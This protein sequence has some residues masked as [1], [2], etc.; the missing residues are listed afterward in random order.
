MQECTPHTQ[1]HTLRVP[2]SP[3]LPLVLFLTL[4]LSPSITILF[5]IPCTSLPSL[6]SVSVSVSN[7]LSTSSKT[8]RFSAFHSLL[9]LCHFVLLSFF[10]HHPAVTPF[11]SPHMLYSH[12]HDLSHTFLLCTQLSL[13]FVLLLPFLL[14]VCSHSITPFAGESVFPTVF[15]YF[16]FHSFTFFSSTLYY[17]KLI[18]SGECCM[19]LASSNELL[20]YRSYS[21]TIHQHFSLH[22]SHTQT[23]NVQLS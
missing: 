1:R 10:L 9:F 4:H 21:Y 17:L 22:P 19:L 3:I 5:Y 7:S 14:V 8:Y 2:P 16:S 15:I 20:L 23:Y 12:P 13:L 18:F 6:S 11:L